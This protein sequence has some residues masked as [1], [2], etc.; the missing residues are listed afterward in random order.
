MS[1]VVRVVPPRR[2][3]MEFLPEAGSPLPV[4]EFLTRVKSGASC[5]TVLDPLI[6]HGLSH[7]IRDD[8]RGDRL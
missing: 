6:G 2:A 4:S 3:C 1:H 5:R 7:P 8:E